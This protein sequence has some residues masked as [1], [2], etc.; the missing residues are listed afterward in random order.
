MLLISSSTRPLVADCTSVLLRVHELCGA[1][2]F[3]SLVSVWASPVRTLTYHPLVV[4]R[5][6][7]ESLVLLIRVKQHRL[8][9][10]NDGQNFAQLFSPFLSI[11][12]LP[13]LSHSPLKDSLS[14]LL[15]HYHF[16]SS[17]SAILLSLTYYL[18]VSLTAALLL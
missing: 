9:L 2:P 8:T 11:C 14:S 4:P 12:L 1:A 18:S 17:S 10:I 6:R 13:L 3:C 5:G 7:S 15:S 16:S